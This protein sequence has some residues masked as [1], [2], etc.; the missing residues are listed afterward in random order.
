M[1]V[2]T[3][4]ADT[5]IDFTGNGLV[6]SSG[7]LNTQSHTLTNQGLL[8]LTAGGVNVTGTILNTST[9]TLAS[10]SAATGRNFANATITNNGDVEWQSAVWEP[11]S[12]QTGMFIN[13][14]T[15]NKT[16]GSGATMIVDIV[17]H[18]PFNLHGGVMTVTSNT[19]LSTPAASYTVDAGAGI[20]I[21]NTLV[22]GT[23]NG[24]NSGQVQANST[25]GLAA[26][27][28][29]NL[30]GNGLGLVR[31]ATS[32]PAPSRSPTS[33]VMSITAGSVNFN[34][35]PINNTGLF[36]DISGYTRVFHELHH[37]Q[38]GGPSTCSR[39]PTWQPG[40]GESGT[41]TS[42]G[43]ILK[44]TGSKR[45]AMAVVVNNSGFIDLQTGNTAFTGGLNQ[46]AGETRLDGSA[47][48]RSSTVTLAVAG[49]STATAN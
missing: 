17:N 5:T 42:S 15:V 16:T 47:Y 34:A 29:L 35:A 21:N 1:S 20:T 3:L 30:S 40:S 24:S 41:L 18:G 44:T 23:F 39:P 8:S 6:W 4:G 37:H 28:T 38:L 19:W 48:H 25:W 49:G 14:G 26:N 43:T 11:S 7:D 33:G 22:S 32:T 27:T 13:N 9:G 31:A 36:T 12:G 10:T 45:A 46:T 2:W